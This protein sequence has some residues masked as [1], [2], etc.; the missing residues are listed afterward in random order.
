MSRML[1]PMTACRASPHAVANESREFAGSAPNHQ[2]VRR[3]AINN[4]ARHGALPFA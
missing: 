1:V 2:V 4:T 3:A